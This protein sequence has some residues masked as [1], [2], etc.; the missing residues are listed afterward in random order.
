MNHHFQIMVADATHY[1]FA[2]I[3][4]DE[5]ASSAKVRGTGIA[6]RSPEYIVQ[7]MLE[8]KAVIAFS[9]EGIWAGFCY[10][11]SWSH[12]GYVANSGL[13]VAPIP[14]IRPG[15]SHQDQSI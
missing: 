14:Q 12:G 1:S 15:Q 6:R 2:Q 10:V 11:E 5:M 13:I 3:I 8:G 9:P 7:K 4:C